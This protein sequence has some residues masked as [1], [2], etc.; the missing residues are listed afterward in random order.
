MTEKLLQFI[1]QYQYFNK[2]SLQVSSGEIILIKRVGELNNNQGPDFS[3]AHIIINDIELF[4]SIEV[5]INSSDWK[6]HAHSNDNNYKNVI[7]HVVWLDDGFELNNV[8]LL[9]LQS[10]VPK[11]LLNHYNLL[12]QNTEVIAC[13]NFLEKI[14]DLTWI[15]WKERLAV[16]RLIEKSGIIIQTLNNNKG[17]WEETLWHLLAYN[18]GLKVNSLFFK[19]VADTIPI[20][21]LAKNKSNVLVLESLLLGQANLL[22]DEF[23]FTYPN[24]LK[25]E[26]QYQSK[27]YNLKP[28]AGTAL[29]L[30]MRPS[31]FPTIRLVQL[32]QLVSKS[33]HLFSIIKEANTISEIKKLLKVSASDYWNHHYTLKDDISEEKAKTIGDKMTDLILINTVVPIVFAYGYFNNE[34]KYKKKAIDWIQEIKSEENIII[35]DWKLRNIIT[36]SAFD[37]QALIQLNNNYCKQKRCLDCAIGNKILRN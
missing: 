17:N 10:L 24:Q 12:M 2:T 26:Y 33:N 3:N 30:R 13:T 4:G 11:V 22:N 9:E 6:K 28:I 15:S 23:E 36:K 16:E 5:H 37:S 27:K 20:H 31:N 19:Q 18:F 7:L 34:E 32:A 14:N 29:F 25:K 8:P 21:I 1:W 35:S